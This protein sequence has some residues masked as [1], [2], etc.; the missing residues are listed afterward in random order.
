MQN[1]RPAP[2][3]FG[4]V[5]PIT[6]RQGRRGEERANAKEEKAKG[7]AEKKLK[8]KGAKEMPNL[9]GS[10]MNREA[11]NDGH[12]SSP[13]STLTINGALAIVTVKDYD[14]AEAAAA[15]NKLQ[16]LDKDPNVANGE[17]L[18]IKKITADDKETY[19]IEMRFDVITGKAIPTNDPM[20]TTGG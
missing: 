5:P 4:L 8:A 17:T 12:Y 20:W 13:T 11:I 16:K 14:Q 3:T 6:L 15:F 19:E 2:T 9:S 7:G 1:A 10:M 18:R